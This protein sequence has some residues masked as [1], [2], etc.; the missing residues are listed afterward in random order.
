MA[1]SAQ[2]MGSRYE[3]ELAGAGWITFAGIML[4]LVG[5]FNIINGIAAIANSNYLANQLLFANLDTWGWFFLIWGIIQLCAGFAIFGGA[6]WAVVVGVV[7]AFFNAIAQ[8]SWIHANPLWALSA[9]VI[10][11]L[12]IYALVVY[13]GQKEV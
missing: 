3:R 5:F 13:G 6:T 8:L 4:M 2:S 1:T 12:I 7:S 11:V 9:M 10:D